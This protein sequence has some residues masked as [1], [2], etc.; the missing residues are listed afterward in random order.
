[1]TRQ[2]PPFTRFRALSHLDLQFL[3]VNHIIGRHA[4]ACRRDLFDR[5]VLA[6]AVRQRHEPLRILAALP[7][8]ALAADP[9]H[10]DR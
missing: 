9:V 4:E 5:A 8:V 2:L 6:V 3:G 1:M 10:R 7:G